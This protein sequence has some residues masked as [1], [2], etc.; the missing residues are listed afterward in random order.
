MG[1]FRLKPLHEYLELIHYNNGKVMEMAKKVDN[2]EVKK[3]VKKPTP[4]KVAVKDTLFKKG[5]PRK[6]TAGRKKGTPNKVTVKEKE[7]LI[8][9]MDELE[10]TVVEDIGNVNAS[11]RLTLLTELMNY[12]KP[13]LSSTK[14]ENDTKVSGNIKLIIEMGD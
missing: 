5:E 9:I 2:K 8:K 14:N 1:F 4:K 13:K 3:V 10:K 7:L 12:I 6:P 11:R